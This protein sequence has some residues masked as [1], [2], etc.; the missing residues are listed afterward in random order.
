MVL[1]IGPTQYFR[2]FERSL[3]S[4]GPGKATASTFGSPYFAV[5]GKIVYI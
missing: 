4:A 2:D 3:V 5:N 1:C